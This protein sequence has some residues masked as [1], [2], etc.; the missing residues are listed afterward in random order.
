M[1]SWFVAQHTP[2][3][4]SC[5]F[6]SKLWSQSDGKSTTITRHA[7]RMVW[8]NTKSIKRASKWSR[9]VV[10]PVGDCTNSDSW[11]FERY[12]NA[13]CVDHDRRAS[14]DRIRFF[15]HFHQTPHVALYGRSWNQNN[16]FEHHAHIKLHVQWLDPV[17][18]CSDNQSSVYSHFTPI[19]ISFTRHRLLI[20]VLIFMTLTSSYRKKN[21][22]IWCFI[23]CNLVP[24]ISFFFFHSHSSLNSV[25]FFAHLH[26]GDANSLNLIC[27]LF[28]IRVMFRVLLDYFIEKRRTTTKWASRWIE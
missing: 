6:N 26:S 24:G 13:S 25:K 12:L 4:H 11:Y 7:E 21:T 27:V 28:Q 20:L 22:R 19:Q 18:S 16:C 3:T 10:Q 1:T 23:Q 15:F 8:R 14:C 5:T 9:W 2:H 17:V